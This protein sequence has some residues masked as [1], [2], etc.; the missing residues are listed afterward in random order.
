VELLPAPALK[1]CGDHLGTKARRQQ[2]RPGDCASLPIRQFGYSAGNVMIHVIT[3]P[4]DTD[5][6]ACFFMIMKDL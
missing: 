6:S 1:A 4:P 3:V 2:L 5:I